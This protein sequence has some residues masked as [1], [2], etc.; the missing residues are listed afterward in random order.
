MPSPGSSL[1]IV[2]QYPQTLHNPLPP[3]TPNTLA[4]KLG[5]P[6]IWSYTVP[7]SYM[8]S[9]SSFMVT[10]DSC[11]KTYSKPAWYCNCCRYNICE[12]CALDRGVISPKLMCSKSHELVW[13]SD[14]S[15]YYSTQ[16]RG[17]HAQCRN[18]GQN[19]DETHWHCRECEFDV[20][21]DCASSVGAM[22]ITMTLGCRNGHPLMET[23]TQVNNLMNCV[24]SRCS[25]NIFNICFACFNCRYILC[26]SCALYEISPIPAHPVLTCNNSHYLHWIPPLTFSCEYCLQSKTEELFNCDICNFTVCAKCSYDLMGLI[27]NNVQLT[28]Q[29]GHVLKWEK[30]PGERYRIN[31]VTCNQCSTQYA[32]VGM[33]SCS[34]CKADLCLRCCKDPSRQA[35][36]GD[37]QQLLLAL[38]LLLG[39]R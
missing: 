32:R 3:P 24:C 28:D 10:C 6:L 18:C 19:K 2:P 34:T 29:K 14:V 20:C 13:R 12:K 30:K 5:H 1:N 22:P 26:H 7:Y 23:N 16:G 27:M 31:A 37:S 21:Q 9:H 33:F 8:N 11:S 17:H 39:N 36:S 38:L 25:G 4:C 35:N 15:L